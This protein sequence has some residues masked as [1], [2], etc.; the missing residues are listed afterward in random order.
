MSTDDHDHD[1]PLLFAPEENEA[2]APLPAGWR[3]LIVDDD[4]DIHAAT[5]MALA[6][7]AFEG[8]CLDM[9]SAYRG[10][11]ARELL[12]QGPPF[13]L[14]IVDIVMESELAGL[15]LVQWMRR[16]LGDERIRIVM[17]T[18]QA[19]HLPEE[20]VIR[21]YDIDDFKEKSEMTA[22]KLRALLYSKLRAYRHVCSIAEHNALLESTVAQRTADLRQ[23]NDALREHEQT[24]RQHNEQLQKLNEQLVATQEHLVHA[25][26][27]ASIGQLA[28]GVAHE[29]N[30]PIGYVFSNFGTLE[31]YQQD[32]FAVLQ[33]YEDAHALI[34]DASTRQR[35]DEIREQ[36]DIAFV[37]DDVP[38]LMRESREGIER[39]RK[40]VQDLKD[41]SRGE[42]SSEWQYA[43]LNKGIDSTLNIVHNEIKYRADVIKQ[44]GSLPEV[45]C[46]P[47]QINQVVLNLVV[48]AAQAMGTQRGTITVSTGCDE[49]SA[50]FSVQ[51]NGAGIATEHLRRIFDPFFTTKPIGQGTGLGLSLSY[52]IVQKHGGRID[53]Q[54][55]PGLGTTFTVTIP[56]T[57]PGA[58][59][60]AATP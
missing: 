59:A 5:R 57:Q 3:V 17:R 51:D 15:E 12:Q 56:L 9:V 48:N 36:R 6:D 25:E 45:Q 2:Q 29:I 40:I 42:A 16:T 35:I 4:P 58:A 44:Y 8:Q 34:G 14:A 13:A 1:A 33:A 32:L 27:L 46:L 43:D 37:K 55:A 28:A 10:D 49:R 30:N 11:T 26:K 24:L 52:G 7:F 54:S 22:P 20:T 38:H 19:G 21:D 50:W 53:V 60:A 41:F 31:E 18:G 39:V 23:A 47:S